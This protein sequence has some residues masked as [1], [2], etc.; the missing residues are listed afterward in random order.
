MTELKSLVESISAGARPGEQVE[1]VVV[2]RVSTSVKAYGGNVESLTSAT[3]AGVGVRVVSDHRQGFAHAGTLDADVVRTLLDEA[4]DNARFG[5][6]DE[7][8]GVAS[9]D[10]VEP[11]EHELWTDDVERRPTEDKVAVALELEQR[12]LAADPRVAG[13]R[14]AAYGDGAAEM[15][16]STNTGISVHHRSSSASLSVSA[17]ASDGDETQIGGGFDIARRPDDLDLDKAVDEAVVRATRLLGATK[18]ATG[19]LTIVLEPRLAA[20]LMSMVVGMLG[21]ARVQKGRSPF[22]ERVGDEIASPLLTVIEDPTDGRGFGATSHDAEGLACRPTTLLAAGRLEGFLHNTYTAR[23][24]STTTTA[25]AVRGYSSTPGVGARAVTMTPGSGD[26]A[27][28]IA[29]VDHGLYVQSLIGLHSGV[30]AVSGDFSVGADGLMI[31]NGAL[32]EPVREAT[33]ASTLQRMLLDIVSVG[34]DVE[35]QP[36]GAAAV[37]IVIADMALSGA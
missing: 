1:A 13:V 2:R 26:L 32:A 31:R 36:G 4:R 5:E 10:G 3:A 20:S 21:A 25:S 35:W 8:L 24:A 33:I 30:N 37:T 9:P 34:A 29:G 28:A 23:R 17:I 27:A 22:A 6:P 14:T 18:P 12:V 11:V 15:A 16:I 7:F 19:R